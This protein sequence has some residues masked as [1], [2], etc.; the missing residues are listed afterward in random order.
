M[1]TG[2]NVEKQF[3]TSP[4]MTANGMDRLLP[5]LVSLQRLGTSYLKEKQ[6][7]PHRPQP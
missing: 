6:L 3:T 1:A 7:C 2:V 4:T 5:P